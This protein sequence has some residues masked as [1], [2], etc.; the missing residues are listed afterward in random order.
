MI[1]TL[2]TADANGV[3]AFSGRSV[4]TTLGVRAA[5]VSDH[6][7]QARQAGLLITR[8]RFNNSSIQQLSWPGRE[9]EPPPAGAIPLTLRPWTS[10]EVEWWAN[11]A[12]FPPPWED[13]QPPF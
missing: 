7:K 9:V 13:A 12:Q 5:T 2:D 11:G 6:W 1:A 4:S 3:T 8:Y 10:P